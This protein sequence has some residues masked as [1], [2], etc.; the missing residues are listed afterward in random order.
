MRWDALFS[1]MEAQFAEGETL[2]V[3][4]EIAERAR[5]ESASVMLVDRLRGSLDSRI[6]VQLL[7]GRIF[8]GSLRHAGA[9][10]L[11]LNDARHQLL[12]PYDAVARYSGLG[13]L[14]LVEPSKVRRRI[15]LST[16]LRSLAR[17]RSGLTVVLRGA[18]QGDSGQSGVIDTVGGDFFDLALVSPGEVRRPSHVRQV[19]TIPFGSLGVIRSRS[20]EEL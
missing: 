9:D 17:D 5:V 7:C 20:A 19:A 12:I 1:D 4:A 14:S 6:T 18:P 2:A 8:E 3:E 13:R 16:A 10:A 11:V 15:G